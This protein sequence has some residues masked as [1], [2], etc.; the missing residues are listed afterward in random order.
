MVEKK[1]KKG[2]S[3]RKTVDKWK[4]K[5][6]FTV[7]AS[8]IFDSKE[9]G[10]IPAEKEKN[11]INRTMKITLDNFTGK[12]MNRDIEVVFKT[13]SVEGQNIKTRIS[14]FSTNKGLLGRLVRRRSSKVNLVK[15]IPVEGGDARITVS[16]LTGRKATVSQKTGIRKIIDLE[17]NELRKKPFEEIVKELLLGSFSDTLF[18][19]SKKI[20][21][22]KKVI[23]EKAIFIEAK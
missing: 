17:I 15:K 6:W 2:K 10:E 20:C 1:G 18:K 7:R 3:A 16:V 14:A 8:K 5:K 22:I 4:R 11:L 19:K 13:D 9:L 12:R 23:P 21:I